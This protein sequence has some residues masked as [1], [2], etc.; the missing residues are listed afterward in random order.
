MLQIRFFF[1]FSADHE[2]QEVVMFNRAMLPAYY[3]ILRLCCQQSRQFTRHLANHQNLNWAFKN[4]TPYPTQYTAV[5]V[6]ELYLKRLNLDSLSL[7]KIFFSAILGC[8]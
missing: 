7:K 8:R 4:I 6:D 2:D 3:G 5:S 1:F